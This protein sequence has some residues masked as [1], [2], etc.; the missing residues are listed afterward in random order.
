[1]APSPR[2][3]RARINS[4]LRRQP[5]ADANDSPSALGGY[6]VGV[7]NAG[8]AL[9]SAVLNIAGVSLG[10][11]V[12]IVF[13]R[14]VTTPSV[15]VSEISVP[16]TLVDQGYN[17]DQMAEI[18]KDDMLNVI[19][20]ARSEKKAAVIMTKFEVKDIT[21]PGFTISLEGIEDALRH[22]ISFAP[23]WEV[24]G[25]I[26]S[27]GAKGDK[28]G[29]HLRIWDGK[30]SRYYDEDSEEGKPLPELMKEAAKAVIGQIDPY[31]LAASFTDTDIDKAEEMANAMANKYPSSANDLFWA[32]ILLGYIYAQKHS[33]NRAVFEDRQALSINPYPAIVHANLCSDLFQLKKVDEAKSECRKAIAIDSRYASAY[34][35]LGQIDLLNSDFRSAE[36][37]YDYA[38]YYDDTLAAAH[39]SKAMVLEARDDWAEAETE[40]R[41]YTALAPKDSAG[42]RYF[43]EILEHQGKLEDAVEEYIICLNKDSSDVEVHEEL[44]RVY[45]KQG[46][47]DDYRREIDIISKLKG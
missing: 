47:A 19:R 42:H 1:M 23:Y 10:L 2:L 5:S 3:R 7:K 26:A 43:G 21:V 24:S 31:L 22:F 4:A 18:L 16:K 20:D 27:K 29:M 11:L 38:I 6:W 15:N 33:I 39:F 44:S 30:D 14:A 12:L 32:H 9:K 46:F 25:E 40:M 28:Y 35:N 34:G 36:R 45:R 8:N 13:W 17:P 37:Y 41:A